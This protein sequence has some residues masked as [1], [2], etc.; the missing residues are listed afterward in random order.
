MM[1]HPC[2]FVVSVNNSTMTTPR[3]VGP[4]RLAEKCLVTEGSTENHDCE[5]YLVASCL[6][7]EEWDSIVV[8]WLLERMDGWIRNKIIIRKPQSISLFL[9]THMNRWRTS[10]W[11]IL[12]LRKIRSVST[13]SSKTE[14][15][16]WIVEVRP[17]AVKR[18]RIGC[19]TN[20]NISWLCCKATSL[21][22]A[23]A[24]LVVLFSLSYVRFLRLCNNTSIF[25]W[26]KNHHACASCT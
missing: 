1:N 8:D 20:M 23:A 24:I 18:I 22:L 5:R 6:A 16:K 25:H 10:T 13:V 15:E 4:Q 17:T 3:L 12:S 14:I 19:Q 21:C 26:T 9:T 7:E 2:R 11:K